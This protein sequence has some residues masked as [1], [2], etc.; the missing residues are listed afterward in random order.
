MKYR[1]G[2]GGDAISALGFGCMR[3]TKKAGS[4]DLAKAAGELRLAMEGGV[5]YFDTAYFYRGNEKA[6]GKILRDAGCRGQVYI[7][8]KMPQFFVRS[9]G[10]FEKFFRESLARLQ[11]DYVDY[12]MMHMLTDLEGL[13]RLLGMGLGQWIRRQ[14]AEGRIRHMGFS[15]HGNAQS[16]LEILHAY[17]WDFCQIQYNYLDEHTQAGREGLLAAAELGMPV[18]AMEPL[19]GGRLAVAL[20]E[21]VRQR[22]AAHPRGWT[23]GEWALHW[24]WDQPEVTCVLSGMNDPDIIRDNLLAAEAGEPGSLTREDRDFLDW[25]REEIRR[26]ILVDC[27]ACGYCMPCPFGVDIPSAFRCYNLKATDGLP[28][29]RLE[30]T[31]TTA[32]RM[33]GGRASLCTRCG[34][35]VPR[36]PQGIPIPDALEQAAG[37]LETPIYKMGSAGYKLLNRIRKPAKDTL[38]GEGKDE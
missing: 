15:F 12:Y 36:C 31:K 35:C 14:K 19:R 28:T 8:D 38:S 24:L 22:M 7:A 5:N 34:V 18:I 21:S 25:V 23:P 37:T 4:I 13:E 30:Y 9:P 26:T 1:Q 6:L 3:L 27:T 20:P 17:P 2:C 33:T 29:A 11:T 10:D 32:F 16:F